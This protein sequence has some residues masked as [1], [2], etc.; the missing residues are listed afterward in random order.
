MKRGMVTVSTRRQPIGHD[1]CGCSHQEKCFKH[2][3]VNVLHEIL[4]GSLKQPRLFCVCHFLPGVCAFSN[5]LPKTKWAVLKELNNN[6][7]ASAR[8][9]EHHHDT[10]FFLPEPNEHGHNLRL[11]NVRAKQF[12]KSVW[13]HPAPITR[14]LSSTSSA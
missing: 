9:H 7:G 6:L 12:L 10:P 4:V 8:T 2:G 1:L 3:D 5:L 14:L 11:P 13:A